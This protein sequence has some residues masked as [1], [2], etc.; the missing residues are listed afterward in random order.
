MGHGKI[1]LHR[2]FVE[3][4]LVDQNVDESSV[5]HHESKGV[6]ENFLM[7]SNDEQFGI[8]AVEED[9]P[10][11]LAASEPNKLLDLSLLLAPGV[12]ASDPAAREPG[13]PCRVVGVRDRDAR[14]RKS[15]V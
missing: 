2:E 12:V 15:V 4:R 3:P 9:G 14:D 7:S 8:S 1:E 10:G 11:R 6:S 5:R 13:K